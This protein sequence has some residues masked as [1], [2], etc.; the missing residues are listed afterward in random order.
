MKHF[1]FILTLVLGLTTLV[2]A[3][4]YVP[5]RHPEA[6]IFAIDYQTGQEAP[7]MSDAAIM[8]KDAFIDLVLNTNIARMQSGRMTPGR[9]SLVI[10]Q[11][12]PQTN[13]NAY[14]LTC[15]SKY[16]RQTIPIYTFLYNVDQNTLYF[17]NPNTQNW[18]PQLI[19]GYNVNNLNNCLAYGKFNAPPPVQTG[20][21][22]PAG[23]SQGAPA[24]DAAVD[25]PAPIDTNL[26][27]ETA[28]PALPDYEQPECPQDGYLWQ[29]GFWSYSPKRNDY[30]WVPGVWVAPPNPGLLWTPPYWGFVGH[31]YVYHSGYWGNSIGFYGGINYGYGYG[32]MGY[33]GGEWHEGHFRYNTAVVRVNV[34]VV[35]NTYV[36]KTVIVNEGPR[37]RYSF[38]GNG[39]VEARPTPH[40]VEAMHERHVMATPEQIRN[41]QVAREDK[42]QF[43]NSGKP[44]FAAE[45][46]PEHGPVNNA[47]RPAQN[48]GQNNN[49]RPNGPVTSNNAP[50]TS[51]AARPG[52][53]PNTFNNASVRPGGSNAAAATN[54]PGVPRGP[55]ASNAPGVP[56]GPGN[57]GNGNNNN[58]R[59]RQKPA[60]QPKQSSDK[61]SK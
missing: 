56:K 33:H 39:G 17:Y 31:F 32:G 42:N 43:R 34:T 12:D 35:H 51:N 25:N 3:Q 8:F 4:N 11:A 30:Y 24:N 23:M 29:P 44:N 15:E 1:T 9:R 14:Q 20:P 6:S 27:V 10:S 28:P 49:A 41:Q 58:N 22:V 19:Q 26:S 16:Y 50:G 47:A 37:S 7:A 46:A 36:D 52:G 21:A 18:D 40:E 60:K 5:D 53:A 2:R 55:G 48:G 45:R 13:G 54:S 38:N 59:S 57:A 61:K